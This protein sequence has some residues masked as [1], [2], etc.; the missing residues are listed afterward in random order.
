M[1]GPLPDGR[2]SVRMLDL[3]EQLSVAKTPHERAALQRLASGSSEHWWA[4]PQWHPTAS[5]A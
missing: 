2:G 4:S 1:N 3:H 5:A